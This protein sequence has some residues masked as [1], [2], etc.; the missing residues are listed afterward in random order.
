MSM[1]RWQPDRTQCTYPAIVSVPGPR[2]DSDGGGLD[3]VVLTMATRPAEFERALDSIEAQDIEGGACAVVVANGADLSTV[4]AERPTVRSVDLPENVG[5]PA[6]RDIGIR[7]C[8]TPIVGLLDDDAELSPDVSAKV[9]AAFAANERLGAVALRLNDEAGATSRRHVPR[10]G[11]EGA[12]RGGAATFFVGA[13]HAIRVEAYVDAGGYFDDLWYGHEEIEFSWR[14][15][16]AGWSI[17]Y[18][19]DAVAFHPRTTI[20]RHADGWRLTGRNRV[21]I[22]R[23]TLP[24]PVAIVHVGL[25]LGL[26]VW[27]APRDCKRPYLSGWLSG[28]RGPIEHRPI[29]WKTVWRLT[30]LGRPPVI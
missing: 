2:V 8:R 17:A 9:L 19:A 5:I 15:I 10:V 27:R 28:W 16:D 24:W 4:L 1:C 25:W 20:S 26:G 6:G 23:R 29:R 14:L 30:R 7:A 18:L 22:A 21:W 11:G 13:A 3:W 12:D